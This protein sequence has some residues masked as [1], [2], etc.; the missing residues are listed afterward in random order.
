MLTR[1]SSHCH[2]AGWSGSWEVFVELFGTFRLTISEQNGHHV[3][4]DSACIGNADC[5]QRHG[6]QYRLT[7]SFTYLAGAVTGIPNLGQDRPA[8]PRGVDK[9]Q[10]L[11]SGAVRPPEGKFATRITSRI[12]YGTPKRA[13]TCQRSVRLTESYAC[14]WFNETQKQRHARFPSQL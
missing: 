2:R 5:L 8:D 1:A 4:A 3:H 7:T 12:C 11:H 10:A 13:S 9:I 14:C 6:A